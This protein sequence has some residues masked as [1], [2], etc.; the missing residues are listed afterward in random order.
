MFF[1]KRAIEDH[2]ADWVEDRFAILLEHFSAEKSVRA[3]ELA[4]P[5]DERFQVKG[6]TAEVRAE[7]IY[8]LTAGFAGFA[9]WPVKLTAMGDEGPQDL[10]SGVILPTANTAAGSFTVNPDGE[11]EIKFSRDLLDRPDD[12]IATFAHELAH[13]LLHARNV[14]EGTVSEDAEL[15]TDLGAVYLGFG[16]FL[17]NSA[18]ELQQYQ[19]GLMGGWSS[20]RQG[21]LTENTLVYA[22][23]L[24][25][26][27][28]DGEFDTARDALKPRLQ[29]VFDRAIKQ[30]EKRG[31]RMGLFELDRDP[32]T[33]QD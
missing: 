18:F 7:Q 30:L 2:I 15:V 14:E 24:F 5:S 32:P 16:A 4:L 6:E 20:K 21:Y 26:S 12:L 17:A 19:D 25:C 29:P 33:P 9:D 28:K 11:V 8:Q 3:T 23:A 1:S 22:T 31:D 10:S 27:I 13:L